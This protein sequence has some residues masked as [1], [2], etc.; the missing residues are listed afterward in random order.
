ME[1][2]QIDSDEMEIEEDSLNIQ[3]ISKEKKFQKVTFDFLEPNS[4]FSANLIM[5]LR[6][7]F[8]FVNWEFTTIIDSICSQKEFGIF[9]GIVDEENEDEDIK[10]EDS[11]KNKLYACLTIINLT[12]ITNSEFFDNL[13]IYLQKNFSSK[14]KNFFEN[15]IYSNLTEVGLLINERVLNLPLMVLPT[16]YQQLFED[17]FFI[18]KSEEYSEIEKLSYSPKYLLYFSTA[19][20]K[21]KESML[22][23]DKVFKNLLFYK[24]EDRVLFKKSIVFE[25]LEHQLGPE[26]LIFM[27]V[28][29][30]E[31]FIEIG[32]DKKTFC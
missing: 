16:I 1:K 23:N 25:F 12:K 20:F 27:L 8:S 10:E 14:N 2:K 15:N 19:V 21:N 18:D 3:N 28:L 11:N 4:R 30:F 22:K 24:I 5:I 32:S 26:I 17:K 7:T 29:K 9:L 31:D 6:K 13:K